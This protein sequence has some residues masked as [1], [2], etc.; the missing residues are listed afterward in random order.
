[1]GNVSDYI[2][3]INQ[4]LKPPSERNGFK[5]LDLFA[6]CGGLS[7]GFEAAGF[8][9][10]GYE[11][12]TSAASTYRQNLQGDCHCTTLSQ[13]Q[14]Y[15]QADVLIGGPPCQPFSVRGRQ[16]GINDARDGF[17]IFIDAVRRVEPRIFLF[18][19]VSNLF[20]RHREYLDL[21]LTELSNL[22]YYV[23]CECLNA[24]HYGVPQRRERLIAVGY[25]GFFAYPQPTQR[26]TT[27]GDAIG[28]TM[29]G[30]VAGGHILTPAQDAYI[31][32]YEKASACINPR[33][34]YPNRPARTLTCRNLAGATSDMQRVRM[35]DGRRR[36]IV[37]REAA[38]LQSFPD[39]FTFQG[40]ETEQFT[41]IGNAVPPLLA[42]H[43]AQ[44]ALQA[45]RKTDH[46]PA[47]IEAQN[48]NIGNTLGLLRFAKSNLKEISEN[49]QNA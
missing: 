44:S 11:K 19:N 36:R 30:E 26:R 49:R 20:K 27:V 6:G 28:D 7:L 29:H 10:V 4:L 48:S 38:R 15:P 16:H 3:L 42:Y 17:P 32:R 18:E 34:L 12:N 1:M 21:I 9:T 35:A 23:R 22:G 31:A 8:A 41:Q 33:D 2:R 39:W 43:L 46:A 14:N 40:S 5:V 25:R 37:V 45:L 13:G 47:Q 24:V